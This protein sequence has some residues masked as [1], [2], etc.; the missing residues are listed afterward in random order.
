VVESRQEGARIGEARLNRV[1]HI[2]HSECDSSNCP[3]SRSLQT[4]Y[5]DLLPPENTLTASSLIPCRPVP[6]MGTWSSVCDG[7]CF[8]RPGVET[9]S[10]SKITPSGGLSRSSVHPIRLL[11]HAKLL[12]A[13]D[14]TIL[15]NCRNQYITSRL[16]N[17]DV[18]HLVQ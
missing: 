15:Q 16:N 1:Y 2:T 10:A 17:H 14:T 6:A 7:L 3:V 8:Q 9:K 12:A 18:I 13:L 4:R 11:S 5:R